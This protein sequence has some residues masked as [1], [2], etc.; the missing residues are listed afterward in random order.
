LL[1]GEQAVWPYGEGQVCG[2]VE[3]WG[4]IELHREGFR[5]EYARPIAFVLPSLEEDTEWAVRLARAAEAHRVPVL[6]LSGPEALVTHCVDT[7]LGLSRATV[8]DLVPARQF[9]ED[10][11]IGPAVATRPGSLDRLVALLEWVWMGIVCAV[12]LVIGAVY[13]GF[14]ALMALLLIAGTI[15]WNPLGLDLD[16]E[17]SPDALAR[18]KLEITAGGLIRHDD[19]RATFVA[20]IENRDRRR[21]A[22]DVAPAA[23]PVD[24]RGNVRARGPSIRAFDHAAAIP[25]G[26]SAVVW[27]QLRLPKGTASLDPRLRARGFRAVGAPSLGRI[28]ARVGGSPCTLRAELRT[29]R[30]LHSAAVVAVAGHGRVRGFK[31]FELGSVPVGRSSR[32][33]TRLRPFACRSDAPPIALYPDLT[34]P[35][36]R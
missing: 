29:T 34:A 28:A 16:S 7:G 26:G 15:G 21:W 14:L 11:T 18:K 30:P 24:E 8:S 35:R 3:A 27:T 36:S 22:L 33:V 19:G 13:Y 4:R 12:A 17:A 10:L 25:P 5:A 9:E 2:I 6:E 20:V 32:L 1:A 31:R 23:R